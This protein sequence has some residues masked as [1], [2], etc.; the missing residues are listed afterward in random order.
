VYENDEPVD[1]YPHQLADG[2]YRTIR[3][4]IDSLTS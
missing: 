4:Y 3:E 1:V 2:T